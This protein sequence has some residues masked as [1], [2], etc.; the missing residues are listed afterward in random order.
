M[1]E[2]RFSKSSQKTS[3]SGVS[4]KDTKR[5]QNKKKETDIT[6]SLTPEAVAKMKKQEPLSSSVT[7]T[8]KK[9]E[10]GS[11]HT[12]TETAKEKLKKEIKKEKQT[13]DMFADSPIIK[14]IKKEESDDPSLAVSLNKDEDIKVSIKTE[15]CEVTIFKSEPSPLEICHI[16]LVTSFSTTNTDVTTDSLQDAVS[17]PH[18]ASV[19]SLKQNTVSIKQEPPSDSEDDFNVDVMLDNLDYEK[20]KLTEGIEAAVKQDLV[21]GQEEAE[22]ISTLA[23]AKSKTQVKRVTWNIQEHEGPQPDKSASSECYDLL[24]CLHLPNEKSSIVQ[25]ECSV[26]V[27]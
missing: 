21:E 23:G 24:D 4:S 13:L 12:V 11:Q 8:V 25:K 9:E 14:P 10:E 6:P 1:K 16:P 22:T 20:S 15:S 26:A 2:D 17:Q 18:P 7:P 3:G 5:L 27:S 19:A